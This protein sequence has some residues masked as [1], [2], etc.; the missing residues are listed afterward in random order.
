MNNINMN[1]SKRNYIEPVIKGIIIAFIFGALIGAFRY[2]FGF[3]V[4]FQ[5]MLCGFGISWLIHKFVKTG[6]EIFSHKTFKMTILLFLVFMAGEAVGFGLSQPWFD[7]LGWLIRVVNGASSE[8]VFGIYS[9]SGV[10]HSYFSDGLSGG[11]WVFLTLFDLT[12]LFFFLL[13]SLPPKKI[14]RRI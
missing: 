11:F 10:V 8:A 4:L 13:I 9:K 1:V 14:K 12:F 7:P 6:Q 3:Y 5:G 2:W